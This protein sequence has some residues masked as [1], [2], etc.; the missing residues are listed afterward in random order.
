PMARSGQP[1]VKIATGPAGGAR[2]AL[3]GG[4]D[5]LITDDAATLDYARSATGYV[6]VP[7]EWSRTY[8]LLAPARDKSVIGDLRLE[9]LREAVH[10]D[11]RPAEWAAARQSAG[12]APLFTASR[13][14]SER[15]APVNIG[16]PQSELQSR[17]CI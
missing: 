13:R 14:R 5:V 4:A 7:L 11:A 12:R 8:V 3:D 9:S 10:G 6:D 2:D 17:V 15:R 1:V 16:R